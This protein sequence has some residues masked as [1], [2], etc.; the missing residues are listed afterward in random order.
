M[1]YKTLFLARGVMRVPSAYF[2]C[3]LKIGLSE[4]RETVR[5]QGSRLAL[6]MDELVGIFNNLIMLS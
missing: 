2:A 3:C 4:Q 6:K 1:G 5:E